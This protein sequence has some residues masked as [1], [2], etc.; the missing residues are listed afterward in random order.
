MQI[1]ET[2]FGEKY[3]PVGIVNQRPDVWLVRHQSTQKLAILQR[4]ERPFP[5]LASA[6]NGGL[7]GF[8]KVIESWVE[9]GQILVLLERVE[10]RPGALRLGLSR[11]L[12]AQLENLRQALRRHQFGD[13]RA[14]D[15]CLNHSGEL[16]LRWLPGELERPRTVRPQPKPIRSW[17]PWFWRKWAAC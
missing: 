8:P 12:R 1:V 3:C 13:V 10:E 6:L 14:S 9:R 17:L 4:F 7:P 11:R 2:G 15:L 5:A 16:Q